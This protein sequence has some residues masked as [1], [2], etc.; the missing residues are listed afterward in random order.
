MPMPAHLATDLVEEEH[1][2]V[3][4]PVPRW[5]GGLDFR[6]E[7]DSGDGPA[8]RPVMV[9]EVL[10]NAGS[11]PAGL[12]IDATVGAGGHAAALLATHLELAVIGI[13]RDPEAL[14]VAERRLA[15]WSNRVELVRADY[16]QL[17]DLSFDRA[18]WPVRTIIVDLGVSSL[19]L[20][21]PERGFSFRRS[22]PLD[23]RMDPESGGRTAADLVNDLDASKLVGLLRRYGEERHAGRI[24]RA[25]VAAR[26]SAPIR[27]T[28]ELA[29]IVAGAV[30]AQYQR[31][32]PATRTFQALRIA[33]NE[34]LEGLQEFFVAA[35]RLLAPGG[36]LIALAFHSLED[37]LVK[38]AFRYLE[39]DCVCPHRL[40]KCACDKYE[41]AKVLTPRPLRPRPEEV[42]S[43]PRSR[44][45]RMRVLERK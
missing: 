1:R 26:Q 13:D 22:G 16:R 11:Q 2:P 39:S 45:A 27:T 19:Q 30:P 6:A 34:E 5:P 41:E 4:F 35:G 10:E 24:A 29:D 9:D 7:S 37:R 23:M 20:D 44:S 36:R 28:G 33:V 40:P 17:P 21:D 14:R 15:P 31:I 8:H 32:H 18:W 25:I 3:G 43:N 12:A 38:H 42:E